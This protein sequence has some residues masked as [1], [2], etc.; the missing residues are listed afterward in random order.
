MRLERR[1]PSLRVIQ[2]IEVVL[3]APIGTPVRAGERRRRHAIRR[4]R[5]SSS[6]A[7]R[8]GRWRA[9]NRRCGTSYWSRPTHDHGV[10]GWGVQPWYPD[11]AFASSIGCD[12]N[13]RLQQHRDDSKGSKTRRSH[14]HFPRNMSDPV[15]ITLR[16]AWPC[17][18][19]FCQWAR[20]STGLDSAQ[21]GAGTQRVR[22][23]LSQQF[24]ARGTVRLTS[25]VQHIGARGASG[26]ALRRLIPWKEKLR[27]PRASAIESICLN[28][29]WNSGASL[30]WSWPPRLHWYCSAGSAEACPGSRFRLRL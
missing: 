6:L 27:R 25:R 12:G 15:Q 21:V 17:A 26:F 9:W 11:E 3:G 13:G 20:R 23:A 8:L 7:R 28:L 30:S 14:R 24:R 10:A 16:S 29:R 18:K 2:A 1:A 22:V 4:R 5:H 19:V